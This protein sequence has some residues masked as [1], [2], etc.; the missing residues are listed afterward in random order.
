MLDVGAGRPERKQV[1]VVDFLVHRLEHRVAVRRPLKRLGGW[2]HDPTP[3]TAAA[4]LT[5]QRK[6]RTKACYVCQTDG[7]AADMAGYPQTHR[8][9]K[10]RAPVG[11]L[12]FG[13]PQPCVAQI[14]H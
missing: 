13:S 8:A 5:S 9:R 10:S 7:I 4:L 12:R 3:G 2:A 6:N 11:S 1:L 14:L